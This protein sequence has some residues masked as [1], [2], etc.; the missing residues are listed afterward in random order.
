MFL[1][2][3]NNPVT[4]AAYNMIMCRPGAV[5]SY[6]T[7]TTNANQIDIAFDIKIHSPATS[8]QNLFSMRDKSNNYVSLTTYYD[9]ADGLIKVQLQNPS[10]NLVHTSSSVINLGKTEIYF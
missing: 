10:W 4:F 8:I 3:P 1:L 6:D 7:G 9:H 5:L 2:D